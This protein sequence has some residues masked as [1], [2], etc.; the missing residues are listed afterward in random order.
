MPACSLCESEVPEGWRTC[1]ACGHP[2]GGPLTA[3]SSAEAARRALESTRKAL[4]GEPAGPIDLSFPRRLIERAEQTDAAGDLGRALDLARAA[5]RG[6]DLAKRQARVAEA[7]ARADVVLRGA[8]EAGIE[9]VAFERTVSKARALVGKGESAGAE[10]LLRRSSLRALD[11]RRAKQLEAILDK[12]ARRVRYAKERGAAVQESDALLDQGRKAIALREYGKIRSLAAKAIEKAESARRYAWAESTLGRVALEVDGARKAGV[13]VAEARKTLTQ[14]R[15]ALRRGAYADV[16]RLSMRGRSQLGEAKRHAA[17]ERVLRDVD[18]EAGR[19]RRRGADMVHP[20]ALLEEAQAALDQRDYARVRS[21]ATDAMDATREAALLKHVQDSLESLRLDGE[22]LHGLGAD[23]AAFDGGFARLQE[24]ISKRDLASARRL[25][26]ECRHAAESARE[27]HYRGVM[28]RTLSVILTNAARGLDPDVARDLL[29]HVDDAVSMGK[30]VDVQALIDER[31]SAADAETAARLTARILQDRD[32]IV[33]LQHAGQDTLA[34]EGKLADAAIRVQERRFNQADALIDAVEHDIYALRELVRSEAAEVLGQARA[35]VAHARDDGVSVDSPIR[36]LHESEVAFGESRYA[37][38]IS[39]SRSSINEVETA[40]H[41]MAQE[42]QRLTA[43]QVRARDDKVATL[44]KRM[45]AVRTEMESLIR[46]HS[47]LGKALE[48]LGAAERAIESEALEE[49]ERHVASAEGLVQGVRTALKQQA[50]ETLG[51]IRLRADEARQSGLLSPEIEGLLHDAET[52]LADGQLTKS[53]EASVAFEEAVKTR[54]KE[55]AAEFQRAAM[56]KARA[57]AQKFITVKKLIDELRK[58]DIDIA[59]AEESL[60]KA[61]QA[62]QERAYDEVDGILA[63]LDATAKELLDELVSAARNLIARANQRIQ[64]A[65]ARGVRIDDALATLNKAEAYFDRGDYDDAVEY[66]RA[67]E[68]KVQE[69]LDELEA[70][71]AAESR[72]AMDEARAGLEA[73]KRVV[74]DLGRADITIV[75][76]DAALA[77]SEEALQAGRY[78]DVA[79]ELADV[80]ETAETLTLGLEAAAKDLVRV[81]EEEVARAKADGIQATRAETVLGN[82]RDAM[83]DRRYVEAIEY[84]KVIEDI[85]EDTRRHKAARQA[86]DVFVELRARLEA[87]AKLGAD[88]RMAAELLTKTEERVDKAPARE[89]EDAIR[90]IN[91]SIDAAQR[92]HLGGLVASLDGLVEEGVSQGLGRE[93]LDELRTHAAEAAASDDLEEVYR[94][95]GDLQERILDARRRGI[96]RKATKEIQSLDDV[97]VQSER[98]GIP[99][100]NARGHLDVARNAIEQGDVDG[101]QRSLAE[102]RSS[103]DTARTRHFEQ[104]Y[105]ARVHTVSTMIANAKRLGADVREAERA[106]LEAESSLRANDMAMADI[107]VKQAEVAIGI[108]LQNFIKNRYPNLVLHLPSSGLQANVWNRYVFEIENKGKLPA[109]NV[110]LRFGGDVETKGLS[111]I[112]ELG[113]DER[114]IV[115]IGL[116]PSQAGT[117]PLKVDVGYQRMFDENRY[118]TKDTK[119]VKVEPEGTYIVEDAFLIHED[120]RLISHQSRKFREAIDEDIFSGMLTV[121]QDFIK[122]SFKRSKTSLRRLEFGDSKILIERS[123]HTFLAAVLVGQEPR[124]LPLYMIQ[125]LKEVEDGFGNALEKWT[126]MMHPLEGVDA[127]VGKVLSVATSPHADLGALAD[128]PV[129]LTARVIDA[130]GVE[131]TEEVNQL[132]REAQSTLETDLSLS[133]DFIQKARTAAEQSR[134]QLDARMRDLLLAAR[135]TVQELKSIGADTGQAELLLREA[136]EAVQE[137]KYDRVQEIHRGLHESLERS[138]GEIAAK[139]V[140]VELA[141]L[142]NEIQVAKSQNLDVREAESYLSK[143]DN[144]IQKKNARQMEDYLRRAK[145]SL[146]RQ[147]RRTVL[148]KAKEDLDELKGTLE[149]AKAQNVDLGDVEVIL[150]RAEAALEA[151]NLKDLEPLI[152]RAETSAKARVQKILQERYPRLFLEAA[153]VGLQANR[154]NRFEVQITN[155]GNWPAKAVTP[156]VLG[157]VDIEGLRTID[158]IAPNGKVSLELGVK[159]HEA[160]TMDLDFEVHYARPLDHGKYQVTDT[161]T[162]RVEAE[163]GY[164]IEDAILVHEDGRLICHEARGYVLPEGR[165]QVA[166]LEAEA[167]TLIAKAFRQGTGAGIR[168]ASIGER[169]LVATRGPHVF[170]CAAVRGAEPAILPLYMVQVLKEI[171]DAFGDRM[172]SWTG[173]P[174]GLP[175]IREIVRKLLFATDVEGVSLG[176]LEDSLVSKVPLLVEKGLLAGQDGQ[177]FVAWARE[178]IASGGYDEGFRIL[179]EV[180]SLSAGPTEEISAQIHR[181]VLGARETGALQLSDEQVSEYVDVLRRTLEAVIQAKRRA[182]IQRDWPV[183]R[184]ALRATDPLVYDAVTA[185]RK[186]IVSQS[187]SKE[188]DI[189]PPT[190]SWR[191]MKISIQVHM[192]SVSAAYRLWAKKIEILLRSQDA[193]K[194]KAG[195]DKGEYS[196]GIE[197]QKVR[198]DPSMVSFVESIPEYVLEEPFQGGVVFLDTRM[199]R[200]LLAEGYAKEVVGLARE[201]RKDLGLTPDRVV[202]IELVCN[203]A[204]HSMLNPWIDMILREANALDVRFV[205]EPSSDAYVIEAELGEQA[206]LLGVREAQM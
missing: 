126:G 53:L 8:R 199:T 41:T 26:T 181:E 70:A 138:K 91:E 4:A 141:S 108:Q 100:G 145:D 196:V 132:L 21:L 15:D 193:W 5:R 69:V 164:G 6:I 74:S 9:T 88:V 78:E 17:V 102:A 35:Q 104:R 134:S 55:R 11:Q 71:R 103:L 191:G 190:E 22:D 98:L 51:R 59:G 112:S 12:A 10:V 67:A 152:D 107:L 129:T 113:V 106:L 72:R 66:A 131:Q 117:V 92:A 151:E 149:E 203:E 195:L 171:H 162:V 30:Q 93:E 40:V 197:G 27:A 79:Q 179:E 49:A 148:D 99:A 150:A 76:A 192:D 121:V 101:F 68:K 183:S 159:P 120:G 57:A 86:K 182:G 60:R 170:L 202:E 184:I 114:R 73:V 189:V 188:L 77:R 130:L 52:A 200:D 172:E 105:E 158:S 37:D 62:M 154:W 13:N 48:V 97:L 80:R 157:P 23:A 116:K 83:A 163:G 24:A 160:G 28:E 46:D 156:T 166:T 19:H 61:E 125:I 144:A 65:R 128:S 204:L 180:S 63:D 54:Q 177:D 194:I 25:V 82:A 174:E 47:D 187:G 175:G 135:D 155:K 185:F 14:A 38:S 58:A 32:L 127:I 2:V 42:R 64:N 84:K 18:R 94:I 39:L 3:R 85:L 87:H 7:L 153:S 137:G 111:P 140:E 16:Q 168:R 123:P 95:K 165:S 143:I 178:A 1:G 89:V 34:M 33:E 43:E 161:S 133:W 147:R 50:T 81:A 20:N 201:T 146:A 124:L 75:N 139:K 90:S 176:P 96:L 31:L 109:R 122:D 36:L 29:R 118:E 44:R 45:H 205:R 167:E 56:E 186:I 115:D 136:E 173:D 142:I 206:F 110:D 198:I 119:E 169:N